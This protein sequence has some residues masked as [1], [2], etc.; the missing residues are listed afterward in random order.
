MSSIATP[1]LLTVMM[2]FL[3]LG[4]AGFQQFQ[5]RTALSTRQAAE[6][7][8]DRVRTQLEVKAVDL[9]DAVDLYLD[10]HNAGSVTISD[11]VNMDLIVDYPSA[12]GHVISRLTYT[13]GGILP[14][15]WRI[16]AIAPDTLHPG[17]WNQGETLTIQAT[18]PQPVQNGEWGVVVV[19]TPNGIT[20]SAYFSS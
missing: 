4:F 11:Y 16:A 6:M 14:G 9:T 20:T 5:V 17:L 15:Q 18:L 8:S 12:Q 10:L 3:V 2:A 1:I 7:V 13:A 19:S